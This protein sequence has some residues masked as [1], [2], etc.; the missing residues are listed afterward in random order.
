M[1]TR[2]Y[3]HRGDADTA[4]MRV[5]LQSMWAGGPSPGWHVGD[6]AWRLF[7]QGL[8]YDLA[9]TVR[10]W[11]D[12]AGELA[13]LAVLAPSRSGRP[14]AA[15]EIEIHA[16][17]RGCGLE[18]EMVTWIEAE[19]ARM[20]GAGRLIAE[21][22]VYED[23]VAQMEALERRGYRRTEGEQWLLVRPVQAPLAEPAVLPGFSVRPVSGEHEAAARAA[24]HR[25]AFDS[26][27]VTAE[28][29]RRLMRTP[30]YDRGLDVVA[31]APDGEIAAFALGWMDDVN[32]VGEF[33]PVGTRAAFRRM[34]LAQA[35]LLYGL[36]RMHALGAEEALVGPIDLQERAA[37]RLYESLG[38]S[39]RCGVYGYARELTGRAA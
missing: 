21:P 10:L 5:L 28:A 7:L 1:S 34:G 36:R 2:S 38:F 30:G 8:S 20:V 26:T 24:A 17:R 23:D 3:A 37:L 16:R 6:L 14:V 39:R 33:E 19:F 11:D 13:G 15:F 29:Y 4:R 35:V 22:G 25:D 32:R 27:R 18:D 9:R 12:P 31:V